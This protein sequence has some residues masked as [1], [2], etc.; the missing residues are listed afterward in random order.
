M[1]T[2]VVSLLIVALVAAVVVVLS[3][4]VVVRNS[5]RGRIYTDPAAVPHRKVGLVLGCTDRLRNGDPNLFFVHRMLA[6]AELLHAGKVDYLLVSGDN[7]RKEYD[8]PTSM[9]HALIARGVAEDRII[10]DYA[11]FRTLD[12][13]V[14]AKEVFG[15][16][17]V[18]IISQQFHNERAL[19][20]ARHRGL[21]AIG[22][23]APA[24][25]GGGSL[26]TRCREHLARVRVLLDV[27]ILRS[28]PHFLGEPVEIGSEEG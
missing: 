28:Q 25:I 24:V 5:A 15:Q 13:V 22:F 26:K 20:I 23:N 10:C 17:Q 2:L 1:K 4:R 18:T 27:Y 12:S 9:K 16:Q 6:A 11:G 19:F 8:E 3:A 21:D 7:R 14:R